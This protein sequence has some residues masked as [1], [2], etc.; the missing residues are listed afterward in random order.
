MSLL[1]SAVKFKAAKKVTGKT[2]GD[3]PLATVAAVK[4]TKKSNERNKARKS[5]KR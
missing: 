1:K 4:L 5:S 3:G 2:L